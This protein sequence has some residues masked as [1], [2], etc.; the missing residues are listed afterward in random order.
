MIR[1]CVFDID[2]VLADFEG[3]LVETLCEKFGEDATMNRDK[4]ELKERFKDAPEI[5]DD[6]YRLMRRPSSYLYL[7]PI[8]EGVQ[9]AN[10]ILD[11]GCQI[12][13]LSSR[14]MTVE[15]ATRRWLQNHLDYGR[16]AGM[17]IGVNDKADFLHGV[18]PDLETAFVIDDNPKQV[19]KLRRMGTK[20]LCWSQPWNEWCFP[21][22]EV[23]R[24]GEVWLWEDETLESVPF[25]HLEFTQPEE[26]EEE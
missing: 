11:S 6:S 22:L 24:Q 26:E 25:D 20:A 1:Y 9:L 19:E 23:D 17:Y 10:R 3:W 2:N 4:Y 16:C 13:F 15:G 8:L 5:L 14:P 21:R 12:L 18:Y 7:E